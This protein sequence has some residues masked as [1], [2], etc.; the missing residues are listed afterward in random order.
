MHIIQA[1]IQIHEVLNTGN[2]DWEAHLG[3]RVVKI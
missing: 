1:A 3:S 2:M